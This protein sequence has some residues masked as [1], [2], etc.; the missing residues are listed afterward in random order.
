ML[1]ESGIEVCWQ[2]NTA[3]QNEPG[4]LPEE[5]RA[6]QRREHW[7]LWA[8]LGVRAA[9]SLGASAIKNWVEQVQRQS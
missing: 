7:G 6:W 3:E 1:S 8:G 2:T 9:E 5:E 4:L